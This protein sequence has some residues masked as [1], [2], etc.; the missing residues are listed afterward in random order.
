MIAEN[1]VLVDQP[2]KPGTQT[3]VWRTPAATSTQINE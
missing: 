2:A 3:A 1:A